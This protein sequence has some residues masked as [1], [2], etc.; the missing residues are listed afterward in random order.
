MQ[1]QSQQ[2]LTFFRD[3]VLL[4]SNRSKTRRRKGRQGRGYKRSGEDCCRVKMHSPFE[5]TSP[6]RREKCTEKGEKPALGGVLFGG[7]ELQPPPPPRQPP[8]SNVSM[9]TQ[10]AAAAV[11]EVEGA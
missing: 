8:Y 9:A 11:S 10:S 4:I 6:I 3:F 2:N 5:A 1:W 7:F